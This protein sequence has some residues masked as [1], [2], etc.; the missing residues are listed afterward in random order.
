ML[1][2]DERRGVSRQF[3][4]LDAIRYLTSSNMPI[5][6][7]PAAAHMIRRSAA[8]LGAPSQLGL[9]LLLACASTAG[10]QPK[11][12]YARPTIPVTWTNGPVRLSG[13]LVVPDTPG[14]HPAVVLI[15]GAGPETHDAP[16]FIMHANAFLS[17]GFAVLA[18][19]KRGSGASTGTLADADFTTLA[20]DARTAVAMLRRRSDIDPERIGVLGRSEGGWLAPMVAVRDR[21][22]AFVILSSGSAFSPA[23]E[24][25]SWIRKTMKARGASDEQIDSQVQARTRLWAYYRDLAAG[26]QPPAASAS[27]PDSIAAAL[28]AAS[29]FMPELTTRV[30]TPETNGM[31]AIRAVGRQMFHEPVPVLK[32]L[33]A[34]LLAAFGARDDIV[35]P[36]ANVALLTQLRNAGHRIDTRVFDGVDHSLAVLENGRYTGYA[37]G[38]LELVTEFAI[39]STHAGR[40]DRERAPANRKVTQQGARGV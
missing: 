36:S 30:M 5:E 37:P 22:I 6:N 25:L 2:T 27:S 28:S 19:D 23:Q 10:A 17:R 21:R 35:Q 14:R 20:A 4:D 15:H 31:A 7:T 32:A 18:Y 39:R 3:I 13:V 33:R 29:S 38:Y 9:A 24:N 11:L 26:K 40:R 1:S 12:E 34:P 16:A 8:S